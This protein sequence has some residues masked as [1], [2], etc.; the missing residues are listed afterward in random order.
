M[1]VLPYTCS[2]KLPKTSNEVP[3]GDCAASCRP[4]RIASRFVEL[5]LRWRTGGGSIRFQ[6]SSIR[7]AG[8]L[9]G[10]AVLPLLGTRPAYP[11]A[12]PPIVENV[13]CYKNPA[14]ALNTVTTGAAP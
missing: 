8:P 9:F 2:G 7:G 3:P 5:M 10:N 1:P 13:A 4:W 11:G 12:A 6:T 14:P